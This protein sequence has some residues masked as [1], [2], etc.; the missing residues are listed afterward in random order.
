[1]QSPF[2]P[3]LPGSY[4]NLQKR[5]LQRVRAAEVDEKII[6]IVQKAY[7]E[8]V[9]TENIVLSRAENKR[10]QTQILKLVLEEM[11]KKLDDRS[12]SA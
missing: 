6:A 10:L 12:S 7:E 11:L 3:N 1:M 4:F 8:A 5:M 9:G 2:S